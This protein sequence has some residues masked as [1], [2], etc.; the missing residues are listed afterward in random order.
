[1]VEFV[2]T[3]LAALAALLV[4]VALWAMTAGN[5]QVAGLCFLSASLVIYLRETRF[6]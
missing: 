3:A 5:L 2:P 1:M 6:A 4:G